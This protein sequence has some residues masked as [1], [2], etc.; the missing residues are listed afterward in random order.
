MGNQHSKWKNLAVP[1][2]SVLAGLLL[3]AIIMLVSGYNP[4]EGYGAMLKGAFGR[5]YNI[6]EVLRLATP[7][8]LTGLG[9]SVANTAGFFNIGLAGQALCGW[10]GAIWIA[11]TFPDLPRIV[12]VPLAIIVGA[13]AGAIWAGIA[14]YLRAQFGTSEVIVT[15]MLNYTI[16]YISNHLVRNVFT[17]SADATPKISENASLRMQFLSDM[18]G[19]SRL[20]GGIFLAVLMIILVWIL[21]KRTTTGFEL[22]AVGMN[23]FASEYAGMNAKRNIV[24]AMVISGALAGMGGVVEGLGTFE[25]LYILDAA[26]QIGFDGMAVSLLGGGNPIGILLSAILF[27][28]LKIGGLKMPSVGIPNE[29]V[30]IVVASII[31]FVGISFAIR[32]IMDKLS[33]KKGEA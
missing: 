22:R 23:P 18:S 21:M 3:G 25:N 24:L 33:V 13:L 31:F 12:L 11:M 26:P 8:I 20:N 28:I 29:I 1:V 16:L 2:I 19:G 14:G 17:D 7:L 10:I 15:I 27:G 32:F 4:V 6:G 30:D 5:T 9:F